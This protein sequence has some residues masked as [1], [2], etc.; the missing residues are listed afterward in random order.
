M[1]IY[2]LQAIETLVLVAAFAVY[3]VLFYVFQR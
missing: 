3:A 2:D 1:D